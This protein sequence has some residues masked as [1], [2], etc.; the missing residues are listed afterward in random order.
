M[1]GEMLVMDGAEREAFWTTLKSDFRIYFAPTAKEGL[2]MLSENVGLVF[3]SKSLPDMNSLDVFNRIKKEYPS[4]EVIMMTSCSTEETGVD[5]FRKKSRDYIT[6]PLETHEILEMIRIL[7]DMNNSSTGRQHMSFPAEPVNYEQEHYPDIPYHLVNGIVKVR[8]FVDQNYSESLTLSDACKMASTSKTY[9]CRFFKSITGHSLRS[10]QH[11][12]K[13]Q[14]A[15]EL[16]KD[17]GLSIKEVAKHLG[18][19]DSNYFSTVYKR[20]TGISPK[21]RQASDNNAD[22][23]G[24]KKAG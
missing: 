19:T 14:I 11:A 22:P 12:V 2:A 17:R 18:Y 10:Y 3:L 9:F 24:L 16:L 6:Q 15:E 13:I 5:V 8:N 20:F 4:T 21:Q 23:V 1:T 7:I